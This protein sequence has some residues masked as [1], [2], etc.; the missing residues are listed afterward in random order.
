MIMAKSVI[1][2]KFWILEEN[3]TRV[4]MMN[5]KDNNYTVHIGKQDFVAH[6]TS[7]L[8][9]MGIEFAVRD[10]THGGHISVM[11]YPTD[12]EDVFNVKEIDGFPT[13][14]KKIESN[15]IHAA[16][17]Y[18]LKFKNGWVAVLCPRLSTIKNN[19]YCGPY[20][21]KM[22]LKSALKYQRDAFLSLDDE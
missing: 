21:N 7:E 8:R 13:Y 9:N 2:N 11:G 15:S 3:A 17:W 5:L 14:T 12:Q 16:G 6:D 19:E 20:K 10:L 18:G 4:G 22:D 1:K